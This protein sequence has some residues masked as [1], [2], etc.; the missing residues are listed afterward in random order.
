MTGRTFQSRSMR[1]SQQTIYHHTLVLFSVRSS[2]VSVAISKMG[3]TALFF[4]DPGVKI[5]GEY[6]QDVLLSQQ[7]FPAV[8]SV[9]DHEFIF[10]QYTPAVRPFS[11]CN[12][13]L[14]LHR[15]W[16]VA[17]KQSR[18]EPSRLQALGRH[19]AACI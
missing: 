6:Y 18:L 2:T 4:V 10:Q 15:S 3:V 1:T 12:A 11:C 13:R 8:K 7:M 9:A 16:S 19:A 17:A 14:L 5:N